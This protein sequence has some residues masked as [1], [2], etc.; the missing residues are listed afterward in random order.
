MLL[1]KTLLH[2]V[3]KRKAVDRSDE[4][5]SLYLLCA[6]V[7]INPG[8][9]VGLAAEDSHAWLGMCTIFCWDDRTTR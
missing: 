6:T 3:C 5:L 9:T 8:H 2:W 7:Y 4:Y 1:V